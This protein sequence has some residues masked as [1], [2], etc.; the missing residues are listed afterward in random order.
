MVNGF[1]TNKQYLLIQTKYK[2]FLPGAV[3]FPNLYGC[4]TDSRLIEGDVHRAE[5]EPHLASTEKKKLIIKGSKDCHISC[6]AN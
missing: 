2:I 4:T 3:A 1:V 6:N 5:C